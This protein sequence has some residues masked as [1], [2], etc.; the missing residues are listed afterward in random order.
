MVPTTGDFS[1]AFSV[2][3][4]SFP[5]PTSRSQVLSPPATVS[6]SEYHSFSTL[7]RLLTA[8][9]TLFLTLVVANASYHRDNSLGARH[10]RI[11]SRMSPLERKVPRKRCKPH[12]GVGECFFWFFFK[13]LTTFRRALQLKLH[14][15]QQKDTLLLRPAPSRRLPPLLTRTM[16]SLLGMALV[17][18]SSCSFRV[19]VA[20]ATPSVSWCFISTKTDLSHVLAKTTKTAGPNG[21]IDFLNCGIDTSGWNPP[22]VHIDDVIV[23]SLSDA[24]QSTSSPFHA[25]KAYLQLFDKYGGKYNIP[26]IFLASFAMQESSCN[27][28]AVGGAGEQGLMQ[29]TKDKCGGAPSGNCKD[30]V[31]SHCP[32]PPFLYSTILFCGRITISRLVL[33]TLPIP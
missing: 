26:P 15:P 1:L 31:S 23:M 29:I 12:N 14:P 16:E 10:S 3:F 33:N 18:I 21:S 17:M 32:S 13:S 20:V 30:P 6:L 8:L 2:F 5:L 4:S 27:P 19:S 22:S 25:C 11:S 7:M 24:I 9:L 28:N